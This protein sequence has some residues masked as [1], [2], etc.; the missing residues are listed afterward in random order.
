MVRWIHGDRTIRTLLT[1]VQ[2]A[3]R[4]LTIRIQRSSTLSR[5]GS[6]RTHGH[7]RQPVAHIYIAD[8][9]KGSFG[10]VYKGCVVL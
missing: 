5:T 7:P 10:E 6:V 4:T 8:S 3:C 9:G 1:T 2:L